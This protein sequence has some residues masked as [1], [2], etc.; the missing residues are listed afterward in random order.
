MSSAP[1]DV[2]RRFILGSIAGVA[3]IAAFSH[4]A[5]AGPLNP[6]AG[7]V[8]P[9]GR[10]L[11]EV[12]NKIPTF[13]NGSG[14]G[15]IP[16]AG[17]TGQ[18]VIG[19]PGSYVLTG[20]IDS[21]TFGLLITAS[22]VTVDLN[23]FRVATSDHVAWYPL[24]ISAASNVTIRNGSTF[25]GASGVLVSGTVTN[26][27]CED[28]RITGARQIGLNINNTNARNAIVRRCHVTDMGLNSS[29]AD[30]SLTITGI[31]AQGDCHRIE[32]CTVTR[33]FYFG[34]GT[35]AYRGVALI[36]NGGSSGCLISGC[37]IS[38]ENPLSGTGLTAGGG[39]TVYRNNAVLNFTTP[40]SVAGATDG[41]GN[42]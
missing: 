30:A 8:A 27:L 31:L 5:K 32:D 29:A 16:L 10:T 13:P 41:G 12:Y 40:Y 11:D 6:P 7:S 14:D 26:I 17:G 15:R 28:L 1:K 36:I 39:F 20:N 9:T 3:G 23:G 21:P 33:F 22:N 2:D 34:T 19:S 4:V 42:V 35:P 37:L 18:I 24:G 25:G 38:H